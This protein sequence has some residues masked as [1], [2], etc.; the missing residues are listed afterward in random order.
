[1]SYL[2]RRLL[3]VQSGSI[4]DAIYRIKDGLLNRSISEL[5]SAILGGDIRR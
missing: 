5:S 3:G 4:I 1:M 2:D